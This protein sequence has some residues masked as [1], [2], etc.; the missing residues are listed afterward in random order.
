MS[1]AQQH[2]GA[3]RSLPERIAR[4]RVMIAEARER[5][6]DTSAWE[7]HL[8]ELEIAAAARAVAGPSLALRPYQR[9]AID[10]ISV[11][12]HKRQIVAL[13][14]GTGKTVIF[15]HVIRDAVGAGGW[16]I[17]LVHRDELVTQTLEKLAV[18]APGLPV[19][20]VKAERDE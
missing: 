19:G 13:P 12:P 3:P 20:V 15:A 8:A 17:V 1:A 5:G 16:A 14:T 4:G 9:E 18:V 2:P 10:A 6:W 11:S 7:R